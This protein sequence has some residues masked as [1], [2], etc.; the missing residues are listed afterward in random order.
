MLEHF[1]LNAGIRSGSTYFYELES[2]RG[3]AILLVFLFHA[4]GISTGGSPRETSLLMSFIVMG[5]TGVTLFFV[6]SGFLLS[7]PWLKKIVNP[8]AAKP[9]VRNFYIARA[10]RVIPLYYCAVLFSII[11]TGNWLVGIKA[12]G[13]VFV[14]FENFPYSVVWWTL[15]TEV[16]FYLLL[17]VFLGLWCS[18]FAGRVVVVA[19]LAAWAYFYVMTVLYQPVPNLFLSFVKTNSVFGRFPAFLVGILAGYLFL[20]CDRYR[21]GMKST[22]PSLGALVLLLGV[23]FLLGSVLK[24]VSAMG[25]IVAIQEWHIYHT[26]ESLLWAAFLLLLLLFKIPGRYILINR[27]IAITGKLSYS[28]YLNHAPILFY[29]IVFMKDKLGTE[30]YL[31]SHWLFTVPA[32]AFVASLALAFVTYRL[33]ELPFL[34]L[35]HKLPG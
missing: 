22:I 25:E 15:S 35:K 26:Y 6:L 19:A 27:P 17:P 1:N 2:I 20:I 7:L 14:G 34:N 5:N 32:L 30:Q 12:L 23:V 28:I 31:A 10:L 3:L 16:Q 33:I 13:F 9:E 24:K 8:E 11:V 21:A 18:G 4:Y 29:A